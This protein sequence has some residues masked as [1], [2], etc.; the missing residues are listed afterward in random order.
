MLRCS[1]KKNSREVNRTLRPERRL[2]M[3]RR[4]YRCGMRELIKRVDPNW[5]RIWLVCYGGSLS[6]L[7]A[8]LMSVIAKFAHERAEIKSAADER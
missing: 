6:I 5:L 2:T 4:V 3:P 7:A 1:H 8:Y